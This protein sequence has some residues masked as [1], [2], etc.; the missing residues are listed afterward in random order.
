MRSSVT[1]GLA[2]QGKERGAVEVA[3]DVAAVDQDHHPPEAIRI[4]VQRELEEVDAAAQL[5]APAVLFDPALEAPVGEVGGAVEADAAAQLALVIGEEVVGGGDPSAGR[6]VPE[7][8]R[9]VDARALVV[10]HR[11][12]LVVGER[13]AAIVGVRQAQADPGAQVEGDDHVLAAGLAA[14]L[15]AVVDER[16]PRKAGTGG[17]LG[18][19]HLGQLGPVHEVAADGVSPGHV[20]PRQA[21]RVVLV[22]Q[23]VLAAVPDQAVG[24]VEPAGARGEVESRAQGL[25]VERVG[26]GDGVRLPDQVEALLGYVVGRDPRLPAAEAGERKERVP[27][28]VAATGREVDAVVQD[29]ATIDNEP[30]PALVAR[31]G[32]VAMVAGVADR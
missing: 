18:E 23:V 17:G 20:A 13:S 24:I 9:G 25:G 14:E 2:G 8:P 4:P 30:Q 6:L 29:G 27:V 12:A 22:E 16:R 19:Q 26:S 1:A 15:V 32:A 11:V 5:V 28:R 21:G 31:G 10:E 7:R 3:H